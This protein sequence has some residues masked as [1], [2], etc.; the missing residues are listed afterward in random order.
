[1]MFVCIVVAVDLFLLYEAIL[2]F[3]YNQ[4][5]SMHLVDALSG[6]YDEAL[7]WSS[8]KH[9]YIILTLSNPTFI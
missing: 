4:A 2:R 1:M 9:T 3:R 8:R 5:L 7:K 6:G